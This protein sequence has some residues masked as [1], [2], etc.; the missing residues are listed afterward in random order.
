MRTC[1]ILG[2]A[3]SAMG[4]AGIL[5]YVAIRVGRY[6]GGVAPGFDSTGLP[7]PEIICFGSALLLLWLTGI[8]YGCVPLLAR[9]DSKPSTLT[10]VASW[11]AIV[12]GCL[13]FVAYCLYSFR[14]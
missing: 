7:G 1:S 12:L 13:P 3:C 9:G 6:S 14:R 2:L 4:W 8:V 5:W 10:R 11:A